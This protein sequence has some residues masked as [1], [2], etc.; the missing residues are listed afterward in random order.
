MEQEDT[1]LVKQEI[2]DCVTTLAKQ[3]QTTCSTATMMECTQEYI[4][5][6]DLSVIKQ[7][8]YHVKQE[9]ECLTK[10][11]ERTLRPRTLSRSVEKQ[12]ALNQNLPNISTDPFLKGESEELP[13]IVMAQGESEDLPAM[14]LA[15]V[16]QFETTVQASHVCAMC[17]TVFHGAGGAARLFRHVMMV[18]LVGD[19][20]YMCRG[21]EY[22]RLVF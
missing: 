12:Y 4:P 17:G 22:I 6:D 20:V 1:M 3:Y 7:E 14:V 10:P 9:T 18:H 11:E 21:D 19:Q 15:Q 16:T 8:E 2:L 5:E 13:A